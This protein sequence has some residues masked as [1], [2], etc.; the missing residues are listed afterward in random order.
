MKVIV[1]KDLC[2]GCSL[3]VDE[4]PD[5]FDMGNDDTA[6]VKVERVPPDAE[7]GCREA[8]DQCPTAAITIEES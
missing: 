5:V 3:C 8:A 2:T 6:S 1:D 7:D 4:C